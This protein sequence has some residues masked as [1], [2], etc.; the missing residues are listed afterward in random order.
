MIRSMF[1]A[2]SGL[3]NH[4]TM[5]DVVGNNIANLNTVGF[6]S[7]S[8]VFSEVLSQTVRGAGAV[9]ASTGGSNPIQIGLGSRIAGVN[10]SMN[11]GALQRTNRS[12]DFAIQGDGFFIV[13]QGGERTYTRA[14]AFSVDT[15]GRLVT[16]DGGFVMGWQANDGNML[17][18]GPVGKVTI[19][20]GDLITPQQTR[21]SRPWRTTPERNPA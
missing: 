18:N 11:Q 16:Q 21:T 15:L 2:I 14:G 9:D 7:S 20:V 3:R 13:D 1:S 6:K 4:Q 19:P 8:T 12:T 17:T 5:M 10:T